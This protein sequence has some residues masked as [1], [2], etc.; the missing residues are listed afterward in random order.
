MKKLGMLLMIA[1]VMLTAACGNNNGTIQENGGK[2]PAANVGGES[3]KAP[4]E[5]GKDDGKVVELSF[6]SF[7]PKDDTNRTIFKE[8]IDSFNDS[9]PNIKIKPEYF[10]D[11]PFKQKMKVGLA[12]NDIP[13]IFSYWT[14]DQFK[15]LVDAKVVGDITDVLDADPD[16]KSS[17]TAGGLD[18]YSYDGKN[19]GIPTQIASVNLWYNK[20]LL[21]KYSINPPQTWD[22]LLAAVDK[23]NENKVT[24][25]TVAGKDRWPL[26]HWFSYLQQRIGGDET[27]P[28]SASSN[29][30]TGDSF[31]KAG[32]MLN[33]LAVAHKGFENGFLGIDYGAAESM[34]INGKAAFY[35]QGDWA[36]GAFTQKDEFAAKVGFVPFPTVEG[37]KGNNTTYQGGFGIGYAM[38]AKIAEKDKAAA[39][40]AL[41]YLSSWQT[42]EKLTKMNGTTPPFSNFEAPEGMKPLA[43]D[44]MKYIAQNA[45]GFFPY[46]DQALEPKRAENFL[47]AVSAIVGKD[48]IDVK[49]ELAKISQ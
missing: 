27:F 34:F 10:N 9:H 33:D 37:G 22:E 24:P 5:E 17:I 29:D 11:E 25:I 32:E 43:A 20:D 38:S 19:Y 28:Q 16:F 35:L 2:E 45:K 6:W 46:Y 26:L 42:R 14:G 18:A 47:N 13:D 12:S 1:A 4:A 31:M 15:T 23:L 41:K 8:M 21:A 36:V 30:F 48:G 44:V 49:Q 39:Y 7:E 3:T 40:E